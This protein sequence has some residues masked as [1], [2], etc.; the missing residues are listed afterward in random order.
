MNF[1]EIF[2]PQPIEYHSYLRS[3]KW[4]SKAEQCKRR[5]KYRCQLCG[6]EDIPLDAHHNNYDNLGDEKPEDLIALCRRCHREWHERQ[7][8]VINL[9]GRQ[10]EL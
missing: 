3:Y 1:R 8:A 2:N 10:I 4:R 5:A 7:R 9:E 6:R